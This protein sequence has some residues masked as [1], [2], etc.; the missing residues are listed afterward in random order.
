[1]VH[2][3]D[4]TP[5][6]RERFKAAHNSKMKHILL[7]REYGYGVP[8]LARALA[9][10]Q[11][12]LALV[13]QA[14][15][16]PFKR[17]MKP[18]KNGEVADGDPRFNDIHYVALP[19]P[20]AALEEIDNGRVELKVTLSYFIEPSP[21]QY[22]PVTPARYRS[23]G[24]RFELKKRDETEADFYRR[25]NQAER[26]GIIPT[27]SGTDS[28]W[29]LGSNSRSA[30]AAGSLH[31]DIWRGRGIDLAQRH[32]LAIYPV[33]GWWKERVKLHRYDSS[34]RYALVLT[35]RSIDDAVDLYT[36]TEISSRLSVEISI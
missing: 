35:L 11:S 27:S 5:R 28:G 16:Q 21:G 17:P 23:H 20:R 10:A 8:S 13:A 33:T 18:G 30:Q 22:A 4:W 2:S 34:T 14:T 32:R 19:W 15:M 9:S 12:D 29:V 36:E 1:M 26:E 7:A 24:L 6:M 25:I 3:A 31:C